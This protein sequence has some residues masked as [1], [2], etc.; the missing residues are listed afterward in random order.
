ML[1]LFLPLADLTGEIGMQWC[2]MDRV[3]GWRQAWM[4]PRSTS[5]FWHYLETV[6]CP[7][8]VQMFGASGTRIVVIYCICMK[9]LTHGNHKCSILN[10]YIHSYIHVSIPLNKKVDKTIQLNFLELLIKCKNV[11]CFNATRMYVEWNA[12]WNTNNSLTW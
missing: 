9:S 11:V 3:P 7:T 12:T 4:F 5:L 2:I 6:S 1:D 8:S 10:K